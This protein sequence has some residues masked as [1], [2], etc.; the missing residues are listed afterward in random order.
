M[1]RPLDAR[2][3]R[4]RTGGP[5]FPLGNRLI[6]VLWQA[7]WL[8]L[9]RWTPPPLHRW[10]GLLLR[11]FG[12]RLGRGCRVHASVRIWLPSQ[13]ELG[14]D[15]LIGPEV[16]LYNQGHIAIGSDSVISQRAHLCA[17]THDIEDPDFQLLLR[18]IALGRRC[19][20]AAEAFVGPGVT[21]G[22]GAVLG[23]RGALF[24]DADSW[25]VYRGNPATEFKPRALRAG[26][27]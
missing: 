19:W 15:V 5:S 25:T 16:V 10:R 20:V 9:A 22:D 7:S 4:S 23:A 14:D 8:I 24:T 12:A 26:V 13:L 27:A 1:A 18:P 2:Q 21:M 3:A 11:L 6:R 17:S